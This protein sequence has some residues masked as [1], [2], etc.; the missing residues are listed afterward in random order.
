MNKWNWLRR[1]NECANEVQVNVSAAAAP[2]KSGMIKIV[3]YKF[4]RL[5]EIRLIYFL[6]N[7]ICVEKGAHFSTW[8]WGNHQIC[9]STLRACAQCVCVYFYVHISAVL[10]VYR[11]AHGWDCQLAISLC[12]FSPLETVQISFSF[13]FSWL[14]TQYFRD[15]LSAFACIIA[16]RVGLEKIYYGSRI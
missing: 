14:S 13:G 8:E 3:G 15:V 11:C 7:V 1:M 9:T 12:G 2:V 4:K 10:C 5:C 6:R 16:R